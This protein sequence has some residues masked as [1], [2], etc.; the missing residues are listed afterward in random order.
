MKMNISHGQVI[1]VLWFDTGD[2]VAEAGLSFTCLHPDED[3][4]TYDTNDASMVLL[5]ECQNIVVLFTGDVGWTG[6]EKVGLALS[7]ILGKEEET[8]ELGEG[9]AG[10]KKTAD[11]HYHNQ[12][13][14]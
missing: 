13:E 3:Y 2:R 1:P 11:N 8:G 6:E 14:R 5:M 10:G 9:L 4:S 12:K 7:E